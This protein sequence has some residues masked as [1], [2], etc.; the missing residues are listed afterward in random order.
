[1]LNK[2]LIGVQGNQVVSLLPIPQRLNA[3]DAVHIGTLLV[4]YADCSDEEKT[5][6]AKE[7]LE[8]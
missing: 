6:I 3:E 8:T 7:V 4:Y 2:F 1:M 5:R